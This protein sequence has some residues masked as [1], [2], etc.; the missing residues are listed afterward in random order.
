MSNYEKLEVFHRLEWINS[1][2]LQ[3]PKA[4]S[5]KIAKQLNAL[6]NSIRDSIP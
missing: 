1:T 3:G 5:E 6:I 2:E 4:D